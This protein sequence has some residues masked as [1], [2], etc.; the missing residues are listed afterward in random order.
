ML[1]IKIKS[2]KSKKTPLNLDVLQQTIRKSLKETNTRSIS[3]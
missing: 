3:W 1:K 2:I